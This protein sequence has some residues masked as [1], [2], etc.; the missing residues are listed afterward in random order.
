MPATASALTAALEAVFA[1]R[2]P[3]S[4]AWVNLALDGEI[5]YRALISKTDPGGVDGTATANISFEID[6]ETWYAMIFPIGVPGSSVIYPFEIKDAST[7]GGTP[8]AKVTVGWGTL[9]HVIPT[10]DSYGLDTAPE[11]TFSSAGTYNGYLKFAHSGPVVT[12]EWSTSAV[13]ADDT[14][15]SY[16]LIGQVT[17]ASSGGGYA[18][19]TIKQNI[20]SSFLVRRI[21]SSSTYIYTALGKF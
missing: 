15:Y 14:S 10:M 8:A 18:V 13:P 17:V 19:T 21:G 9:Q 20:F 5:Q 11:H 1:S 12:V 16:I 4:G 3:V 2:T 6:S 7:T